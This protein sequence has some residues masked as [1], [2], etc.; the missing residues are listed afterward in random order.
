MKRGKI[1]IIIA[2]I[3]ALIVLLFILFP[4]L[5]NTITGNVA[6]TYSKTCTDSDGGREP[7]IKGVT[8]Y[9]K[10]LGHKVITKTEEDYCIFNNKRVREY[11]CDSRDKLLWRTYDCRG[12]CENG[13]CVND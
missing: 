1:I 9:K 4:N 5:W 3:L 13:A 10:V 6:V 12:R 11:Y 8:E 7:N 2:V